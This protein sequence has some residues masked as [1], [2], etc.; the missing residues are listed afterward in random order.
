M[1][2]IQNARAATG[3]AKWTIKA[4]CLDPCLLVR[5]FGFELSR[6]AVEALAFKPPLS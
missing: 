5:R 1:V 4:G 3:E 6:E 2:A